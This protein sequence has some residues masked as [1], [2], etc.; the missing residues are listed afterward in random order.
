MIDK[1]NFQNN[2]PKYWDMKK[3]PIS[4][5]E[6]HKVEGGGMVTLISVARNQYD[7]KNIDSYV[8]YVKKISTRF[9]YG[10]WNNGDGVE[11]DVLYTINTDNYDIIQKHLNSHD[12]INNM[13]PQQVAITIYDDMSIKITKNEHLNKLY[14]KV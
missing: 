13:I 12:E 9:Y 11:Y 1:S 2:I 8:E 6:I 7:M 3:N 5:K 4:I 14:S 10:L